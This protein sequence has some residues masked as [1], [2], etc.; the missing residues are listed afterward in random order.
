METIY[1][2]PEPW[3]VYG[4]VL[5]DTFVHV[6]TLIRTAE[7]ERLYR[8]FPIDEKGVVH[9]EEISYAGEAEINYIHLGKKGKPINGLSGQ[10]LR[11]LEQ[12]AREMRSSVFSSFCVLKD[13]IEK[14][15]TELYFG[16]GE[17]EPLILDFEFEQIKA[18]NYYEICG[19]PTKLDHYIV[20]D[21]VRLD[22][23]TP[24]HAA[25][26][27]LQILDE[28]FKNFPDTVDMDIELRT[29]G[30]DAADNDFKEKLLDLLLTEKIPHNYRFKRRST[31]LLDYRF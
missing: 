15:G 26:S 12:N 29:H 19:T 25:K 1:N 13:F 23:Y 31:W 9:D 21:P 11:A 8:C 17:G 3:L 7:N 27:I 22:E 20:F 10:F 28:Y 30:N 14:N 18:E 2:L 4:K 24:E 6:A 16:A 5:N